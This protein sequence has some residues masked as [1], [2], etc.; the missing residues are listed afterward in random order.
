MVN[1]RYTSAC[2]RCYHTWKRRGEKLPKTCPK[3]KS[4]YWNKPRKGFH[5]EVLLRLKK[6]IINVHDAIIKLSGGEGGIRDE[7]GIYNSTYRL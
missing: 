5:K 2:F 6:A 4:P 1:N 3:C 7:G